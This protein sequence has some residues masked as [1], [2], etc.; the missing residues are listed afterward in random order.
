MYNE[1]IY[2]DNNATTLLDKRVLDAML[3]YFTNDF[4]N[5]S[6]THNFGKTSSKA[7][8]NAKKYCN[9]NKFKL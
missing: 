6:S 7:V 4:G 2:F 1:I 5:P 3:P 8:N 9:S